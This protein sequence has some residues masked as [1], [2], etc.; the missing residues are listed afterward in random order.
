MMFGG[1]FEEHGLPRLDRVSACVW[2]APWIGNF[3]YQ[4]ESR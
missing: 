2:C 4:R 1:Q 3:T